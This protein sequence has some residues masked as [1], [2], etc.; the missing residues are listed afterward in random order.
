LKYKQEDP[1]T[2][3]GLK[4]IIIQKESLDS[5]SMKKPETILGAGGNNGVLQQRKQFQVILPPEIPDADSINIP[6]AK[7]ARSSMSSSG[8]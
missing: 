4:T 5:P 2:G 8:S 7:I 1:T 6:R 3:S